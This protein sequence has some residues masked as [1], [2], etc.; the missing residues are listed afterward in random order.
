MPYK[1]PLRAD[2]GACGWALASPELRR[3]H[4][5]EYGFPVRRE[6]DY[7]ERLV[8]E[9]FQAGLS[10]RTV[11]AKRAAL[12]AAL[13]G[14]DP[15]RLAA[16]TPRDLQRCLRDPAI[17]RNRLK[18]KAAVV[19]AGRFRDLQRRHGSFRRF[20]AGLPLD[21]RTATV[22]AFRANFTFMGPEI[23]KEFLMSTGHWP[24]RH[25]RGCPR[26]APASRKAVRA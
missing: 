18:L 24:V 13:A 7:L 6:R 15:D 10:W 14:F 4:D 16:F 25:E 22:R 8:L 26:Y 2:P 21:D 23:V 20:L 11:L 1:R 3:Y 12:R 9:I 19:N 17:I 5:R